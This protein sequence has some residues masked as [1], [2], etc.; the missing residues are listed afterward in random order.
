MSGVTS[1]I[2]SALGGLVAGKGIRNVVFEV[3]QDCNQDCVFCYNVWK[4]ADY[5]RGCLSTNRTKE[6]L[7][8]VILDYKPKIVT[9]S[10]GE[11]LLRP[12]LVELVR[13][14]SGRVSC[15]LI[16]NGTLMT[17]ERASDLVDAGVRIFEFTLLSADRD[18]HNALVG[19]ESF[20]QMIEGIASVRAAGGKVTTTFVAMRQNIGTLAETIELNVALGSCA[21]LLNRYNIGGA[22]IGRAAEIA[23]SVEQ[24]RE[25]LQVA[26]EMSER[27]GISIGCGV[28]IPPCMLDTSG[29][30][31]V[32]N[33]GCALGTR[34]AYP[35]VDPLG[36]VRWCNHSAKILGNVF[37]MPMDR[38][39]ATEEARAYIAGVPEQCMSCEYVK[40]CRGGCR[41]AAEVCGNPGGIDP[42]VCICSSKEARE[43]VSRA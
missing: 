10:G 39:L 34:S 15:N 37:D 2:R 26:D 27:Y 20:D 4:C 16:T 40:T 9:F 21:V 25:A 29:F 23:P 36:N 12:D 38:I 1:R 33:P 32:H 42:F 24:L 43:C 17:D 7:D 18:T 30:K 3:T 19:R 8:R 6:L 22:G 11:P 31:N 14:V 13:H 28:P 41:A 35:T 5:P